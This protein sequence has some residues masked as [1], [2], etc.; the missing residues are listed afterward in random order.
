[1]VEELSQ[2]FGDIPREALTYNVKWLYPFKYFLSYRSLCVL[3]VLLIWEAYQV[4]SLLPVTDLDIYLSHLT[5]K[6]TLVIRQMRTRNQWV[7]LDPGLF[8]LRLALVM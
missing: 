6:G 4:Y 3:I 8:S 5:T 2:S 7:G 1:M